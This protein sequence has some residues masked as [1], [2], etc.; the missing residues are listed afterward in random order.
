M[1]NVSS[2]SPHNT[3][4]HHITPHYITSHHITT[5]LTTTLTLHHTTLHTHPYTHDKA[6]AC[7]HSIEEYLAAY[8]VPSYLP[9]YLLASLPSCLLTFLP[10]YLLTLYLVTFHISAFLPSCLQARILPGH[11]HRAQAMQV[12]IA[13]HL[14]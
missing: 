7:I 2:V 5:T 6:L 14:I 8:Q 13:L 9:P 12:R 10:P 1:E 11:G 4:L 3:T